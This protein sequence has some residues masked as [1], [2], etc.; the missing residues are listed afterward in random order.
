MSETD[1]ELLYN[2][3]PTIYRSRDQL[4]GGPLRT[5]M[6]GLE[7]EFRTVEADID[8]LYNNWFIETC[9]EWAIPYIAERVGAYNEAITAQLLESQRRQ[10]ANTIGYRRR[11]GTIAV[12]EHVIQDVTGWYVHIL[13]YAQLLAQTQH[14][15]DIRATRGRFIDLHQASELAALNGAFETSAHMIDVHSISPGISVTRGDGQAA[16][17]YQ[18]GNLGLF[19]WRLQSYLITGVPAQ[20]V[21]HH[22]RRALPN[23]CFTFDPLGRDLPLFNLS[24]PL[25]ELTQLCTARNLPVQIDRDMLARDLAAYA[26]TL[27]QQQADE[28]NLPQNSAYYGPERGLCVLLNGQPLP[29]GAI[30]SADL[31][32]WRPLQAERSSRRGRII[33]LDPVLGRLMVLGRQPLSERDRLEVNYCYGFSG[34]V[35]GGPYLRPQTPVPDQIQRINVLQGGKIDTL[36]KALD[37]WNSYCKE[38]EA[39]GQQA[40]LVRCIIHIVDNG[41]YAENELLITLPKES[42]LVIEA[43]SGVR[44]VVSGTIRVQSPYASSHLC[45]AGLQINGRL[46]I[47]GSL[48]LEIEH[49]TLMP[50][51][52]T[53]SHNANQPTPLQMTIERSI[54]GPIRLHHKRA[55]LTIRDSIIDNSA[56]YAIDALL[57]ESGAGPVAWL[58]RV[59]VLGGVQVQELSMAQDVIF[60][61]PVVVQNQ[62]AGQVSFSYVPPGSRTPPRDHCQ[63]ESSQEEWDQAL[64]Q[65]GHSAASQHELPV[66]AFTST[67]YGDAAYAQLA[68]QCPQQIQ[69]GA[70]NGSQMGVFNFL[71]QTQRQDNL[72]HILNEY[73]PFGL[74]MGTFYMT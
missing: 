36:Q 68:L 4:Q 31:S 61:A 52:L 9:D 16:G 28:G 51:G 6:A 11:K 1:R 74:N 23:G 17:K 21:N 19:V 30:I 41:L 57:P 39:K 69:R 22:A 43:S 64:R 26:G 40:G 14:M 15:A 45:L 13:E 32:R 59:T 20:P 37:L 72:Y 33:A 25:S 2:L 10:V 47:E 44:P 73:L 46:D 63:P 53:A 34:D 67:R 60:T 58:E 71:R 7:S 38:Q 42:E 18:P 27:A 50:H 24:D 3:L 48:D 55:E 49:C 66:P 54:V 56:G 62:R 5:L 65:N 12:L 29:P 70:S 8:A 35:G